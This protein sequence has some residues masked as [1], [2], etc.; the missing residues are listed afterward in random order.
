MNIAGSTRER[1]LKMLPVSLREVIVIPRVGVRNV[2]MRKNTGGEG[3]IL[4]D[5]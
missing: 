5:N 1:D 4:D 3:G 2:A